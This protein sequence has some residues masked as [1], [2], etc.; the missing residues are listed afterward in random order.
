MKKLEGSYSVEAA[1]IMA[2]FLF[3]M[4][5]LIQTCYRQCRKTNGIMQMHRMTETLRHRET[6]AGDFLLS[7][8]GSYRIEVR[9][10]TAGVEGNVTGDGWSFSIESRIFEPEEFMRMLTLIEE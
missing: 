10:K 8:S 2:V 7:A 1:V 3:S 4:A 6:E 5:L 9:R